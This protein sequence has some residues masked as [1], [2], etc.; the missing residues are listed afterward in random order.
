[1]RESLLMATHFHMGWSLSR[2]EKEEYVKN[3][4]SVLG[5]TKATNTIIGDARVRG[6]S[7][8]ERKR[9]NIGVELI[10]DPSVLFMDVRRP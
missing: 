7:G 5:L 3:I 1:V 4:I 6:V 8:G 2:E 9:V 10:Q